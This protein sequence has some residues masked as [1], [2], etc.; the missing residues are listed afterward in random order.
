MVLDRTFVVI[1]ELIILTFFQKKIPEI[2]HHLALA[3]SNS[4]IPYHTSQQPRKRSC[5][6][7]PTS[8]KLRFDHASQQIQ[9]INRI[10]M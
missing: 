6:L 1:Q 4:I 7:L 8:L 9:N 2:K 3:H 5:F 10:L